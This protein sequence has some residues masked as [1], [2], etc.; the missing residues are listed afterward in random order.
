[1][2]GQL[3]LTVGLRTQ[4]RPVPGDTWA[5]CMTWEHNQTHTLLLGWDTNP[6][7]PTHSRGGGQRQQ[8]VLGAKSR[9]HD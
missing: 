9:T 6:A 5:M 4:P 1:M 7:D 3:T 8:T 2:D